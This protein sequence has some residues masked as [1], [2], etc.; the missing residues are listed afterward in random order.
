MYDAR[1]WRS[2]G[3]PRDVSPAT[4]NG[5]ED[6]GFYCFNR[7]VALN[8]VGGDPGRFGMSSVEL[9]APAGGGFAARRNDQRDTLIIE[10]EFRTETSAVRIVDFMPPRSG[11]PDVV[12]IVV[13]IEGEV[14]L[15]TE[16]TIRNVPQAFSHV[17]LVNTAY[18]LSQ[19]LGPAEHRLQS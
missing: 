2:D 11:E 3:N 14:A 13:G 6:T 15:R 9:L 18:N 19:T 8:E 10:S 7:F 16:L 17:G 4:A 5:A 1:T 12:R